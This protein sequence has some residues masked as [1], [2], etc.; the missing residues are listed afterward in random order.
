MRHEVSKVTPRF[1]IMIFEAARTAFENINGELSSVLKD[2]PVSS[3]RKERSS[4]LSWN[5]SLTTVH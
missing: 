5:S 1:E 4:Y 2:L 3:T